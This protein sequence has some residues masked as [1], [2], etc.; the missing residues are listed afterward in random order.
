M[1]R[2][3]AA[4]TQADVTRIVRGAKQAGAQRVVVRIG[5]AEVVIDLADPALVTAPPPIDEK[6]RIVL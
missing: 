4:I 6:K 5:G 2:R 1:S 3:P